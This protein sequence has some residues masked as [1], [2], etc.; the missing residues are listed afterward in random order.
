MADYLDYGISDWEYFGFKSEQEYMKYC[1]DE[2]MYNEYL[3]QQDQIKQYIN[4]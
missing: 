4:R 1:Y 2:V 3:E